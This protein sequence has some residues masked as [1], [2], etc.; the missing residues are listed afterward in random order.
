MKCKSCGEVLDKITAFCPLCGAPM[1]AES[2]PS[3]V[4]GL[5]KK[6]SE[7]DD[8]KSKYLLEVERKKNSVLGKVLRYEYEPED[9]DAAFEEK[10]IN[11][12]QSF[13]IPN[14]V[15]GIFEFMILASSNFDAAVYA[16]NLNKRDVSDAW[17]AKIEQA[18][19]KADVMFGEHARFL[20]IKELYDRV[21]REKDAAVYA[22]GSKI[23]KWWLIGV[24]AGVATAVAILIIVLLATGPVAIGKSDEEFLGQQVTTAT[25]YLED[26]GFTNLNVSG[27]YTKP[28]GY[29]VG[30][31][32]SITVDGDGDFDAGDKFKKDVRIEIVYV[33]KI[34]TVSS[35][36]KDLKDKNY[37]DVVAL[38]RGM[39]FTNI[40][41]VEKKDVTL[42]WFNS[43]GDV[44][45]VQINGDDDFDAGDSFSSDAT[46]IVTYHGQK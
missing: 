37:E 44:K 19:K 27:T 23:K 28:D 22:R 12:I 39:G 36:A 7:I 43:V 17:L 14:T 33:V 35:G 18:Y 5:V 31:I 40:S 29:D 16:K 38:L 15:D 41:V 24:I 30:D 21:I 8:E 25:S 42:G 20:K 46:V 32:V 13:P 34:I 45:S 2:G 10:R 11:T 26:K 1:E 3:A 4:D 6:L 9:M